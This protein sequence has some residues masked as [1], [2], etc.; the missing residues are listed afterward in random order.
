V[1]NDRGRIT[2]SCPHCRKQFSKQ[3]GWLKAQGH[4]K[5]SCGRLLE[6]NYDQLLKFLREEAAYADAKFVLSPS[7]KE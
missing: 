4:F 7:P 1:L 6:Y 5:C 3:I 2:V